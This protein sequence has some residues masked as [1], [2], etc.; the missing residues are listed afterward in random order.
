[1]A[2]RANQYTLPGITRS[3]ALNHSASRSNT[4]VP[5]DHQQQGERPQSK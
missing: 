2:D 5:W 1:M 3:W 4:S